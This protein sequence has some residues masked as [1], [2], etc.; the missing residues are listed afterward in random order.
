[1]CVEDDTENRLFLAKA[2]LRLIKKKKNNPILGCLY[3]NI[4][5]K[6]MVNC[7]LLQKDHPE[8]LCN[9]TVRINKDEANI[10]PL[11]NVL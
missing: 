4:H 1:M 2:V 9:L 6:P 11:S 5:S 10:Y 8:S 3:V 7:R